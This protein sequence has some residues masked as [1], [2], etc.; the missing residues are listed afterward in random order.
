MEGANEYNIW[1]GHYIGDGPDN[2]RD[3]EAAADRCVVDRDAGFTKADSGGTDR[4]ERR[5]FCVHFAHG[6]CAKGSDCSFYHRI[7]TPDD[8]AKCDEMLD[9]FG[10]QKHSG[11]RDDM[12]GVGSFMKPC[13]TLF[14]G[15]LNK[16]QYDSPKHLEEV[17]WRHFSEWGE[18]ESCNVIHRLSIA[19]P[20]YRLRTSAGTCSPLVKL[21]LIVNA[22]EFAKE[23]MS[24]QALEHKEILS[25]RWAHD[26]PNPVAQDSISRADKDALAA[27][28][29]ARGI[30]LA[31][32]PFEYPSTYQLPDAKRARTDGDGGAVDDALASSELSHVAY[33]NTDAQYGH[34]TA[35]ATETSSDPS[36]TDLT[37]NSEYLN[38][39]KGLTQAP[40][41]TG[42]SAT[43]FTD[44]T[45][46]APVS[47]EIKNANSGKPAWTAHID[48]DTG[49]TYYY[50]A[51]SG[52][53]SW[54]PDPNGES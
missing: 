6:V 51:V 48:E 3:R 37:V 13:R 10:R 11:H 52:E 31:T 50:N 27:L 35:T 18:L 46:A 42:S 54:G 41:E 29:R 40:V 4:R 7:P 53:S 14:V 33:P 49:A 39:F 47:H 34:A 20:R 44:T 36:A 21:M 38:Y 8:D 26:D 12:N 24:Q 9:C 22:A 17:I 32:A 19:F 15:N 1:Y 5:F 16:A 2:P 43:N 23:A 45:E 28:V 30:S 25:I